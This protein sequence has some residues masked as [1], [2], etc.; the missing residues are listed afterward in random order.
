MTI[1]ERVPL[2]RQGEALELV[3]GGGRRGWGVREASRSLQEFL[4][5]QS[6]GRPTLWWTRTDDTPVAAVLL[7]R[8]PGRTGL[9][10]HSTTDYGLVEVAP[11]AALLAG[12][13][14]Q[15]VGPEMVLLQALLLPESRQDIRAFA[16]AGYEQLAELIFLRLSVR[17]RPLPPAPPGIEFCPYTPEMHARFAE[18]IRGSYVQS[19]DCPGLEGLRDV[20]EIIAGHKASGVYRPELWTVALRAGQPA[21]VI[22]LSDNPAQN[23]LEVVYMGVSAQCRRRGLGR[24]LLERA[25]R[26]AAEAGRAGLSLAVDSNNRPA[27]QLYA[28]MG[29]V[30]TTRRLAWVR[31]Y[32]PS[33]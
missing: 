24:A 18:A 29:F 11:L 19:L 23:S 7:L 8:S 14:E 16:Q 28:S 22:L 25:V 27:R 9:V 2:A 10:V 15:V 26:Q 30:A 5:E 13:A 20:E 3:A 1:V 4:R 6:P 33:R 31:V 32:R 21:G 17:S 12:L